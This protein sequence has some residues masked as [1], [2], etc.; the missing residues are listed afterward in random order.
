MTTLAADTE[1]TAFLAMAQRLREALAEREEFIRL[2]RD[3]YDRSEDDP[4]RT[5]DQRVGIAA[6]LLRAAHKADHVY[7]D[8]VDRALEDYRVLIT[9]EQES[10]F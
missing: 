4:R 9:S 5:P 8:R 2:F 10:R 3:R 7:E 6:E 1:T